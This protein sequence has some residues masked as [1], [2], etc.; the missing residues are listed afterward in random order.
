M[1]ELSGL[2]LYIDDI[3]SLDMLFNFM[4]AL[5][6]WVSQ[7]LQRRGMKDI[8]IALTIANTLIEF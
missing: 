5:Q 3:G 2:M 8:S 6:T 1:D 4:D 7:E